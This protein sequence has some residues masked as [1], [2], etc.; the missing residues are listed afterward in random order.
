MFFSKKIA[1]LV[2]CMPILLA[3]CSRN[4]ANTI[5]FWQWSISLE[6]SYENQY[7]EASDVGNAIEKVL[8]FREA[9]TDDEDNMM[10]NTIMIVKLNQY[11]ASQ[12][13][14]KN[15]FAKNYQALVWFDVI[16]DQDITIDCEDEEAALLQFAYSENPLSESLVYVTQLY[17]SD[18][19][20]KQ[21]YMLSHLTQQ[22]KWAKALIKKMKDI[23]CREGSQE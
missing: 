10:T 23:A 9:N 6:E 15:A 11:L 2:V 7:V 5:N 18:T 4:T 16:E 1:R 17:I 21:S 12:Q 22:K 20:Q 13:Q 3:G 19:E 8:A 14:F